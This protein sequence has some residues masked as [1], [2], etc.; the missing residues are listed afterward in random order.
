MEPR[1]HAYEASITCS[2]LVF[3]NILE[4]LDTNTSLMKS[5]TELITFCRPI[6]KGFLFL[7]SDKN[8]E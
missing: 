4:Y 5:F 6:K 7:P 3:I 2:G 1:L 8:I